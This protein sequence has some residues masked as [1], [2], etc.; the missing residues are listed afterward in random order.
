[1][2]FLHVTSKIECCEIMNR[3]RSYVTNC[4]KVLKVLCVFFSVQSRDETGGH[5]WTINTHEKLN[6]ILLH[7]AHL[8]PRGMQDYGIG[9]KVLYLGLHKVKASSAIIALLLYFLY[10]GVS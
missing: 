8:P 1:M 3:H 9:Q 7:V 10:L 6:D 5:L 4:K 2:E